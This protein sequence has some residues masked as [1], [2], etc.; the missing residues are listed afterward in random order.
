MAENVFVFLVAASL[1]I[2]YGIGAGLKYVD[3]EMITVTQNGALTEVPSGNGGLYF[4]W[5][6]NFI[7]PKFGD[8]FQGT[9]GNSAYV[10]VYLIFAM[11]YAAYLLI[12]KYRHRFKS[13]PFF[14]LAVAVVFL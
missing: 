2:F 10:A 4:Q 3:M 6:K 14:A 5:F 13:F 7:G 8:R 12:D 1:M 9:I 11:F